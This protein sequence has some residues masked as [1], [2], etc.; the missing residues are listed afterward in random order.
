M[1]KP[2][3]LMIVDDHQSN[4]LVLTSILE[5]DYEL[6]EAQDGTQ[7]LAE[8]EREQPDLILLDVEMPDINGYDVCSALKK[9]PTTA[10]IP[11][12][13]VSAMDLPEQRLKGFE[14]GGDDYVVKPVDIDVL[15]EKIAA[16]LEVRAGFKNLQHEAQEA[17]STALEAMTASS[18]MGV[19]IQFMKQ[20]NACLDY[21]QLAAAT[22]KAT[23]QLG[24]AACVL[25]ADDNKPIF[26]G[27]DAQS[28]EAR[29]LIKCREEKRIYDFGSRTVFNDELVAILIKNMPLDEPAR[30]GRIKDNIAALSNLATARVKSIRMEMELTSERAETVKALTH[31]AEEKLQ[32]INGK[33]IEHEKSVENIMQTM[34]DKLEDK[35]MFLGLEEDQELALR[36][37]AFDASGDIQRLGAI[38]EELNAALGEILEGLYELLEK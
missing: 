31:I 23:Q 1:P 30:Y 7:C 16:T 34:I 19:L 2:A 25:I 35:L 22:M 38:G 27:C 17:M 33:I 8:V 5:D 37:L 20:G 4:R 18:E 29:A 10:M 21:L 28:L 24:L 13:F 14:A 9:N 36:R 15:R 6:C 11:I 3:K 26:F 12:I 32:A